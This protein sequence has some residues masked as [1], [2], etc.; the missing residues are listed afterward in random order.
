VHVQVESK[1][2]VFYGFS[3]N[4]DVIT[5]TVEAYLDALSQIV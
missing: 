1:G 5:A 3:A 2:K 4:T